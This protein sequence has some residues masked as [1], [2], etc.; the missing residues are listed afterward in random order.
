VAEDPAVQL[1][2]GWRINE[3]LSARGWSQKDLAAVIGRPLQVVNE[4]INTNKQITP[5]TAV[6]LSQA[7]P[8]TSPELWANLEALYR[9]RLAKRAQ[10]KSDV[11]RRSRLYALAPI[12]E[13]VSRGWIN[14]SQHIDDLERAVCEFLDIRS[15]DDAPTMPVVNWQHTMNRDPES[16]A[17][18]AWIKRVEGLVHSQ[19]VSRF[20]SQSFKTNAAALFSLAA[21]PADVA[22]VPDALNDLGVRFVVVPHLQRTYLDGAAFR[23]VD[24][25]VVA[26][27]LRFDR[28]DHFWFALAHEAA[29]VARGDDGV[30]DAPPDR[31]D[32]SKDPKERATD[33][34]AANWLIDPKAYAAFRQATADVP[35]R[36]QIEAFADRV[37]RHPSIVVGR[38]QHDA[39]IT[40]AQHRWA[41]TTIRSYLIDWTDRIRSAA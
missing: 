8:G 24:G 1:G 40:Y 31:V 27:T 18:L 25:P 33:L 38:L 36:A 14:R 10:P 32:R 19:Q 39:V 2:P 4:I 13:L 30:L 15:L 5:E 9:V 29:H 23:T 7:F 37:E 3:E 20:D 16:R 12:A 6:Q 22:R 41:H 35:T 26:L 21:S 34:L 28:L 17:Q 11:E